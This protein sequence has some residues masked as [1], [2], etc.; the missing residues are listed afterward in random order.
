MASMSGA[1]P[2]AFTARYLGSGA[3]ATDETPLARLLANRYGVRLTVVDIEPHVQDIFEPIIYSL[4]EP[5][6]D[7]SAIPS[8]LV[9]QAIAS[10][11]KVAL[12]GTGGDELFGGYRRHIGLL[13]G[14]HYQRVPGLVQRAIGRLANIIPEPTSGG[15]SVNRLKR[16]AAWQRYMDYSTR[17]NWERRQGIYAGDVRARIGGRAASNA[18]EALHARG[19]P[20]QGLRA[21]LYLD[22]RTYLP[23][24]ILA[25]SDRISMAHSL[26]VRV[27]FV[28]HEFIDRVFPLRDRVKVGFGRPKK[29]LRRALRSRLP[30]EHFRA[31]KRGFIGPTAMW[32]RNELREMVTDELSPQRL[33]RLGYFDDAAVSELLDEHFT[34][35]HNREGILWAVLCFMTWHRLIV[36]EASPSARTLSV[37]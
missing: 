23:D 37:A 29:L 3:E 27:P 19:G 15:L 24:D 20:H 17:L 8:W 28:D 34:R 5:H 2:H 6:A 22:Y 11:Y 35:R 13:A 32:L 31:P 26:E 16:F 14:E 21:A 7:E 25:L 33:R 10:E 9:S 36:E 30:A 12:S 18:F 4:D 1:T